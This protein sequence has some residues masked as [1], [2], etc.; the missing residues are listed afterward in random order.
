MYFCPLGTADLT[1]FETVWRA[2]LTATLRFKATF[3]YLQYVT[4]RYLHA[5]QVI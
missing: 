1:Y 2:S 5:Q 4:R 3:Y